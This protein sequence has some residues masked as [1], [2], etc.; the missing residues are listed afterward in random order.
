M[1]YPR[2]LHKPDGFYCSVANAEEHA[3]L[4]ARGWA[5]LPEGHVEQPKPVRLYDALLEPVREP[6]ID[7]DDDAPESEEVAPPK[8]RG[9]KPKDE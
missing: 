4:T 6:L 3:Q 9:R 5:L 1:E 2:H 8:R 7:F